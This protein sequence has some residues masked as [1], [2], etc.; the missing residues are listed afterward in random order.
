MAIDFG[1]ATLVLKKV[2]KH[3]DFR[4]YTQRDAVKAVVKADS[5][6]Y[7]AMPTGAGKS[8]CYQLPAVLAEGVTLVVSPL[9]ALM[10]DQLEHLADHGIH[11]ETINSKLRAEERTRIVAD[12]LS[13]KPKVK[14]LYITPE[15]AATESFCSIVEK[16][17]A[18][19]KV[20][21]FV[22]DEAHCVSQWGHDFRADYLKLGYFRTK[23]PGVP[24]IALT[25]TAT[26]AVVAD[27]FKQLH[28]KE[29]VKKFKVSSF[30]GNLYYEVVM[31]EFL[32][33]PHADLLKFC[34]SCLGGHAETGENWNSKGC[35]IVYCRSREGCEEIAGLLSRKGLPARPYHA[36]LKGS[37]RE[38]TQL[39]WMDGRI[40]VIAATISFGMG[41]D[42]ANVRFVVHW[43]M[44]KS[45]A[46]YYQES[47]RAGRDRLP[48]YCRLYY[49]QREKN[50]VAF[51][52]NM[53]NSRRKNNVEANKVQTKAAQD[54]FET[55]CKFC[56]TA[57]CRHWSIAQYFGDEK[58]PCDRACDVCKDPK[59]IQMDILN[60]QRGAFNTSM[61]KGLGS[62]MVVVDEDAGSNMYGGGRMGAK[63]ETEDYDRGEVDSGEEG[64][65]HRERAQAEQEKSERT[66]IIQKEFKKRKAGAQSTGRENRKEE[67]E[68]PSAFCPLRDASSQ[69]IPKLTVKTRE[70]CFEMLEKAL[71]ENFVAAFSED[72]HRIMNREVE[73]RDC[74]LNAE[75]KAFLTSKLSTSYKSSIM[76][77]VSEAR[78]LTQSHTPHP[79]FSVSV[80]NDLGQS[81][82]GSKNRVESCLNGHSLSSLSSAKD[83]DEASGLISV[84][85]NQAGLSL[86]VSSV[87]QTAS[88]LL[89]QG[90]RVNKP[91]KPPTMKKSVHKSSPSYTNSSD[92]AKVTP[93][94]GFS[95]KE[96]TKS[97]SLSI[98]EEKRTD[99]Y[100]SKQENSR[101]SSG[102]CTASELE[103]SANGGSNTKPFSKY[104]V[105]SKLF[106]EGSD[107][108][109]ESPQQKYPESFPKKAVYFND[110][111]SPSASK[112]LFIDLTVD[113]SSG[114]S[115]NVLPSSITTGKD[116][117]KVSSEKNLSRGSNPPK[118][119]YF[120]ER[121]DKQ[122]GNCQEENSKNK[123][124]DFLES[125]K[126]EGHKIKNASFVS[127]QLQSEAVDSMSQSGEAI[128]SSQSKN[129]KSNS[130]SSSSSSSKK[131][132]RSQE[133]LSS[134][135]TLDNFFCKRPKTDGDLKSPAD[136][137]DE[138]SKREKESNL[139]SAGSHDQIETAE[140]EG[141]SSE[142]IQT[143]S[144]KISLS[145]AQGTK[146]SSHMKQVADLVV[147]YLTP[148][149]KDR[150]FAS[151]DLF[152]AVA[153][154]ITQKLHNSFKGAHIAGKDEAKQQV[155]SFMSKHK[156]ITEATDL[157]E[158]NS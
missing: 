149:Y 84:D 12:L 28:L 22:V 117:E 144:D 61:K 91:F 92:I 82:Q 104:S 6:V 31:K 125:S 34:L 135:N 95:P 142:T 131:R 158:L 154:S 39:D 99:T 42:K 128:T 119:V 153:K 114:T 4:S 52:I 103:P 29:P 94:F 55:L 57:Q 132:K 134:V 80:G 126:K 102:F 76:K 120:F 145:S 37:L 115:K 3:R 32:P 65:Y 75:H 100:S 141:G 49:S 70:H 11:A 9:I 23:I 5:D 81:E 77:L 50:T 101:Q 67:F 51:L 18:H 140:K 60:M 108:E 17:H 63:K 112:N 137:K 21:Y 118:I 87:F 8:L 62:A 150:R 106:G 7:V 155:K 38:Q 35:G 33:D 127:R 83:G 54:S 66:S 143:K 74:A 20:S 133:Q 157:R 147:K 36:G 45:M 129:R 71:Y 109:E 136:R 96:T 47:G 110:I 79:C 46:G 40:P 30:R 16:M 152:K 56:E 26:A 10:Q 123:N 111:D 122:E 139:L 116:K 124:A 97:S 148:Y 1:E 72:D 73:S 85:Q 41:V 58:P 121:K 151:K 24:C 130:S 27:I 19:G 89:S 113:E 138:N 25:A 69:R 88:E 59:R 105:I 156:H 107:D 78:K 93:S 2:F 48:A 64:D 98:P 86:S 14:L 15:Q 44:P 90:T 53:E 43:T 13:K 68:A 146:D